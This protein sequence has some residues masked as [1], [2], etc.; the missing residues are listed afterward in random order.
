MEE[1]PTFHFLELLDAPKAKSF[2]Q[3]D[4]RFLDLARTVSMWSKDP[5]TKVGAVIVRP[6]K[7]VLSLGF[8]GFPRGCDDHPDIYAER[9]RKYMRVVHA[10]V[11]AVLTAPERAAGCTVYVW[12]PAAEP[13]T[14]A[15][16]AGAM[17]QAGI[18]RVVHVYAEGLAFNERWLASY[19][20]AMAMY[21]EAQVEMACYRMETFQAFLEELRGQNG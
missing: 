15:N 12:P 13:G 14:C 5:S 6:D 8:N 11:N 1:S 17:I 16:C 7:T 18:K 9:E 10:E 21:A 2:K 4:M 20:E 19:A 3:W